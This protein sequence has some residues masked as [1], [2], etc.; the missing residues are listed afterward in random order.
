MKKKQVPAA[1]LSYVHDDDKY[2]HVTKFRER[3]GEEV[4]MVVGDEFIIFQDRKDIHWGQN[5]KQRLEESIDEVTFLIPII[6]PRFFNRPYCREELQRFLEREKQ[7]GRNDLILPVYFVDTPLLNEDELRATDELA[8]AIAS[9]QY[10]DWRNLRHEPYTNPLVGRTLEKLAMQIRDA[11]P[12][13]AQEH[14]TLAAPVSVPSETQKSSAPTEESGAK[15]TPSQPT[16]VEPPTCVVD[17]MHR[18]DFAT[19]S[20]AISKS[21]PGTRILVRPG[22]YLEGLT[23]DKPLEIIGDGEPGEVVVQASGKH[24]LLFQTTMGRVTNLTLR[25]AG[26][27]DWYAVDIAQGRLELEDCDI[28]SQSLACVAI[29]DGADPRL[30]RNR[31]HDGKVSGVF[32][33]ENGL[34]TLEDND[35]FGNIHAGVQVSE[36]GNPTLRRNRIHDNKESGVFVHNSG[37]GTVEDNDILN[38]GEAGVEVRERG[39]PTVR[40]NRINKNS[41]Q[42]IW[43]F[44]GGGGTFEGNDLRDN[45]NGAWLIAE[46]CEANVKRSNNQE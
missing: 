4:Q 14:R 10:A 26:G 31:I 39:N 9:R 43:V 45:A 21:A 34:G 25:Q 6:T 20:E 28:T 22:L 27:E 29:H 41:Y 11:L 8:Q 30:R 2:E 32:V 18:G 12:R 1:F 40:N 37:L 38:N 35:I 42:A 7:L 36:G 5:W 23:I 19:I 15:P 46:D 16:K 44:K 13:V 33:Y 24:A 3:L 17:S